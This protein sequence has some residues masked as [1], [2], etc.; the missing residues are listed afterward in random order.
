MSIDARANNHMVK[1]AALTIPMEETVSCIAFSP[2][3]DSSNLLAVGTASR[4]AIKSCRI[5][6]L[7][8]TVMACALYTH[9]ICCLAG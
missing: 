3:Q 8:G 7:G 2:H 9:S 6:V 4:I 5:K 1:M